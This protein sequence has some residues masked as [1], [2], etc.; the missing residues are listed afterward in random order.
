MTTDQARSEVST[1]ALAASAGV[2]AT[3][4]A[5]AVSE[6]IAVVVAVVAIVVAAVATTD[7]SLALRRLAALL[8]LAVGGV[9]T[10]VGVRHGHAG[11]GT[12]SGVA[13][14][15]ALMR[16]GSLPALRMVSRLGAG[17]GVV[18]LVGGQAEDRVVAAAVAT[19]V[20]WSVWIVVSVLVTDAEWLARAVTRPELAGPRPSWLGSAARRGALPVAL[21][22]VCGVV[23]VLVLP[24]RG[25]ASGDQPLQWRPGQSTTFGSESAM[26]GRRATDSYTGIGLDLRTRGPIPDTP[27]MAVPADSPSHWRTVVLDTYTG[28]SWTALL[29]GTGDHGDGPTRDYRVVPLAGYTGVVAAPGDLVEVTPSD[30][31]QI[32]G[33]VTVNPVETPY[34]VTA[35][36]QPDLAEAGSWQAPTPVGVNDPSH[37][38]WVSLPGSVT[39]RTADLAHEWAGGTTDPLLAARAIEGRLRGGEYDYDLDAPV[40]PVG[41]D[42]VDYF[43]FDSKQGFCE[44]FASAEV[45]LLRSLGFPARLAT[46]YAGGRVDGNLRE[47]T[48]ADG[49]AWVEVYVAGSG[50]VRSDPT[51]GDTGPSWLS[52]VNHQRLVGIVIAV[53]AV[54]VGLGIRWWL[55][56]RP[57]H[58][59]NGTRAERDLMA[60][61]LNRLNVALQES[62]RPWDATRTL[63]E[64]AADL[65]V[66]MPELGEPLAVAE[67]HFYRGRPVPRQALREAVAAIDDASARLLADAAR[68]KAGAPS[69]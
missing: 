65:A 18:A 68:A 63:A 2:V 28:T 43:L 54:L 5:V 7:P 40:A 6:P 37:P 46:G 36:A 55:R 21:M 61:A 15:A 22:L 38:V 58:P 31:V 23:A 8:I 9:V 25:G 49:H 39:A 10:A 24:S 62:G 66:E 52:E 60:M 59:L 4:L 14:V 48:A 56:R 69:R 16:A 50:W 47:I 32:F 34:T 42:S 67:R 51:P 11:L 20:S 57:P 12:L 13:L 41:V 45:V 1:A 44:H 35:V 64:L 17:V 27:V 53:L 3:M 29:S 33:H 30:S 19:L 26:G